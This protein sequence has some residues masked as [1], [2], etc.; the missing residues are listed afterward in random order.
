MGKVDRDFNEIVVQN[1]LSLNKILS[2]ED[3][4]NNIAS[5]NKYVQTIQL[6]EDVLYPYMNQGK[7]TT[8]QPKVTGNIIH[9]GHYRLR[10][11]IKIA[12][13]V[14]LMPPKR[15]TEKVTPIRDG[16]NDTSVYEESI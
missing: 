5:R 2:E 16:T 11:C 1:I 7:A 4:E 12:K 8:Y 14:A 13:A 6:L 3:I 10:E 15:M 9:D